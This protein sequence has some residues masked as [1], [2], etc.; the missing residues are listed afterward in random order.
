MG[1]KP[2][3]PLTLEVRDSGI[4]MSEGQIARLHEEFSQAD[5]SVTRRFGGTGLGMAITRDLVLRMGG[6]ITAQ[7]TPGQGSVFTVSLPLDMSNAV[8]VAETPRPVVRDVPLDGLRVLVAD[9]N[10]T[11]RTVLDLMLRKCGAIVTLV[12]DGKAA[13]EAWQQGGFDVVLLDIAMPVMDGTAALAEIRKQEAERNLKRIPVVAVTANV[14][15]DQVAGYL[16]SGFDQSLSK[17]VSMADL[18]RTLQSL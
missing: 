12:E 13:V 7:S 15:P 5:S 8:P 6:T 3:K 18:S 10:G 9:D 16:A 11:N 17:P 14:M 4:G 1:G 2:G